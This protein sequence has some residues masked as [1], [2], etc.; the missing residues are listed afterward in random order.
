[1]PSIKGI[2]Y[3]GLSVTNARRSAAW[4]TDLLGMERVHENFDNAN[5]KA[6]WNEVLLKEPES[7][8]L[9]G[10]L[11]HRTNPGGAFSEFRTGLDHFELEVSSIQELDSWREKLDSLGITHSGVKKGRIITV[12]DPDNI[13]FEFFLPAEVAA[14]EGEPD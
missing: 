1:M 8:L 11:E 7:G 6:D 14:S 13:Q 3:I 9:I 12:R 10:L 4:Y 5:W 2:C